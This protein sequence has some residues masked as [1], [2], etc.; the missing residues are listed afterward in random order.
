MNFQT[1]HPVD[2]LQALRQRRALVAQAKTRRMRS[3]ASRRARGPQN[4]SDLQYRS[5]LRKVVRAT[6][7]LIIKDL[8][9]RVDAAGLS[10]ALYDVIQS[11][12][13]AAAKRQAERVS[14]K[15]LE[16]ARRILGID[17][18]ID[19]SVGPALDVF[20]RENVALISSVA[21]EQQSRILTILRENLG[22]RTEDLSAML[23]DQFAITERRAELIARDQT[24]KLAGDL[25]Q[26]RQTNAG[27]DSYVW[28]TSGD[29]RVREEHALL[30]G[31]TFRWDSPP[32]PG[33][34]GQDYQCRCTAYPIVPGFEED[35]GGE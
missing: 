28:T 21:E 1:L 19:P 14:K 34:P 6:W 27:V 22:L 5:D 23:L 29:E 10:F 11:Q 16:D 26:I 20:V 12:V 17:P 8:G 4:P 9:V 15:G 24:L 18:R 30:D 13:A 2:R 31:E 32:E 3:R 7:A 33:H 25:T 35:T